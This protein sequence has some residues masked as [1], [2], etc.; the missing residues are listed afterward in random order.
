V[1]FYHFHVLAGQITAAQRADIAAAVTRVHTEVTGAP[2]RYV[3]CA[4]SEMEPG[5]M[6]VAGEPVDAPRMVGIIRAGRTAETKARLLHGFADA[7]SA[8]TGQ[9]RDRL[10]VFLQDVPGA[11][12]LEDGVILPDAAQDAP[13]STT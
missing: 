1:P 13:A 2:A 6:F 11:N 10:A 12:V 5:S 8:V 9:P 7:W 4:F 3:H